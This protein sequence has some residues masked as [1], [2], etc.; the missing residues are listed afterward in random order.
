MENF[1]ITSMTNCIL[2]M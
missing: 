2:S 1:R